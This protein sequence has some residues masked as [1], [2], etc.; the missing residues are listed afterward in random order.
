MKLYHITTNKNAKLIVKNGF[1]D[2]IGSYG[3]I[4]SKT[5]KSKISKG[6]FLSNKVFEQRRKDD[7]DCVFI[8]NIP[9]EEIKQYEWVEGLTDYREWC[10]PA[11]IVN[12]YFTNR[13]IYSGYDESLYKKPKVK[14]PIS[15]LSSINKE[16]IEKLFKD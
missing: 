15:K 4:D 11:K 10:I 13:K 8:I 6:V 3:V 12:K 5:G 9:S 14:I 1:K 7:N 2:G 16:E